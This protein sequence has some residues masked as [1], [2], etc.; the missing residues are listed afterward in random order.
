MVCAKHAII[1]AYPSFTLH[2]TSF[3]SS[4]TCFLGVFLALSNRFSTSD[5]CYLE[6]WEA[7]EAL[8]GVMV[9]WCFLR[10][11]EIPGCFFERFC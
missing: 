8:L 10:V 3:I 11:Y 6:E 7:L 2:A 4:F 1:A 5:A 9:Q